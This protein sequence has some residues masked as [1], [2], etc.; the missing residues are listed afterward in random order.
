MV[1]AGFGMSGRLS[2]S[3]GRI[4]GIACAFACLA[5]APA[6]AQVDPYGAHDGGGFRN[7]L[8]PGSDG[9]NNAAE[10]VQFTL[11]G[12]YPDHFA[13]QQPLYD[14]LIGGARGLTNARLPNFFKDAT[15]GVRPDQVESTITP[16]PGVTII[17]DSAY[18]VPHIYGTTRE[19]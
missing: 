9:V 13:D 3:A 4:V 8:P 7:V 18:G 11:T 1:R 12:D 2:R 15:F 19:D 17:R 6:A 5:A 16:R 14:G 10:L